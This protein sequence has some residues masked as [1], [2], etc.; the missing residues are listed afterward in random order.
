MTEADDRLKA[1]FAAD[2]PP[3]RDPAF[4]AEVMQALA[5]RRFQMDLALLAGATG[6][7]GLVLW[8]LWPVAQ[9]VLVS[10][11]QTLAPAAGALV[12]AVALVMILG[13]RPT[14][15]LGLES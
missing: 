6:L 2:E 12:V 9:P 1:L 10:M 8:A 14:A 13:G 15:A 3:A 7:G 11:S 5:R 4:T